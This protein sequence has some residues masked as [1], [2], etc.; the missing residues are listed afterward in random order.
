MNN[1]KKTSLIIF[2]TFVVT[3]AMYLAA[4]VFVPFFSSGLNI[5]Q[6]ALSDLDTSNNLNKKIKEIDSYI[7]RYYINSTDQSSLN[8]MAVK[9]Y[10]TGLGDVYS[11]YYTKS[12]FAE[13]NAEVEGNY[14]GVGIEVALDEN[15]LIT[16]L[17]AYKDAP[18]DEAGIRPGDKIIKINGVSVN[19]DN[20]ELALNMMKGVGKYGKN[21]TIT[22]TIK[23]EDETF[24]TKITRKEITVQSVSSEMLDSSIGYVRISSFAEETDEQFEKQ[25]DSLLSHGAKSLI[26]DIRNNGGGLLTTV[27]NISD[28]LLPKGDILTIKGKNAKP[29]IFS[30]NE[31]YVDL[32]ICVLINGNSA[33]ASEVLAGALKDHDRAILVGETTYGKGVVQTLIKLKDGSGIKLTT[34]KYYTP[35]GV[36]IDKKGIKP[37]IEVKMDLNKN[38]ALLEKSEDVQ[39]QEAIKQLLK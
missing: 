11:Q 32:P 19:G 30:S 12:E 37:D 13:L 20:Y 27:V 10:M 25:V 22:V 34:S 18:A 16:V 35:N 2:L 17:N 33:S 29:E 39:L 7:D 1:Q 15:N 14:K 36:C 38:L 28:Y 31:E 21:D 9:G 5:V 3:S 8:D 23:R 26:I 6:S 4:F 24:E